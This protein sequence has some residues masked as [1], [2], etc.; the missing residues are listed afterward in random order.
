[1]ATK[2]KKKYQE[3]RRV[4]ANE[5]RKLGNNSVTDRGRGVAW[6][7]GG[8]V[9]CGGRISLLSGTWHK[10]LGRPLTYVTAFND[11]AFNDVTAKN[12]TDSVNTL[13]TTTI[14]LGSGRRTY[15]GRRRWAWPV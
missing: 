9:V 13:A 8:G 2:K 10:T 1:M 14:D 12:R 6:A 11:E 15:A 3:K 7:G 4:G 5:K